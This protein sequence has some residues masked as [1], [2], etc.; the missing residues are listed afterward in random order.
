[1]DQDEL[2]EFF[3]TRRSVRNFD[4]ARSVAKEQLALATTWALNTPSVCNRQA[5]R[6][7]YFTE[8]SDVERVLRLQNGNAGFRSS[9]SAVAVVTVDSRLFTGATERNQR[10]VDGGLFAM[11]LVWALHGVGLQ[12]CML[13]WSATNKSSQRLR[14]ETGIDGH[15][16]I[17]VLIAV[18]H[19][20]QGHR[21][22]RSER[23]GLEQVMKFI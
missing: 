9:V 7:Y 14:R 20:D 5:G 15:E 23:R 21:V 4:P 22:A 13:N 18:G 10:W 16:D 8:Q 1:M 19:A 3:T 6:V 11:T 2:E 12:T 17:V